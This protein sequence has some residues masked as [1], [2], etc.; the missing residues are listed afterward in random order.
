MVDKVPRQTYQGRRLPHLTKKSVS[1]KM[2]NL[3]KE[4]HYGENF[5]IECQAIELPYVGESLSMF[6]L[7]PLKTVSLS[8][9]EKKSTTEYILRAKDTFQMHM[10]EVGLKLPRFKL[11]EKLSL[12]SELGEM[13]MNDLF[14]DGK[15]N[16][17]GMDDRINDLFVSEVLH[18]AVVEVNEEGT[19][20]AAVTAVYV[21][22]AVSGIGHAEFSANRPFIFFIQDKT[23]GS[24][25]FLVRLV[26]PTI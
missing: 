11:D 21:S 24:I 18:S 5:E 12:A 19:E 26:N 6:I 16:L 15:A 10:L 17:S 23:T 22:A 1:V 14:V 2:M 4:F 13:G 7:L 3:E 9:V 20:G 25:L 8:E